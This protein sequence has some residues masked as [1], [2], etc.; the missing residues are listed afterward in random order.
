MKK[1]IKKLKSLIKEGWFWILLPTLIVVIIIL[2]ILIFGNPY[3]EG[4]LHGKYIF[5]YSLT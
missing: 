3:Q 4:T 1:I 5:F 2:F